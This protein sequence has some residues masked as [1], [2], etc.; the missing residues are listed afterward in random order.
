M[1]SQ[2]INRISIFPVRDG[3]QQ[4]DPVDFTVPMSGNHDLLAISR[5]LA[6]LVSGEC[7]QQHSRSESMARLV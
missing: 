2:A 7:L 5:D 3:F 6:D 4:A 1:Y